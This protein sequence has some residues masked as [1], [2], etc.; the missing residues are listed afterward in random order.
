MVKK[1]IKTE[2]VEREYTIP[3]RDKCRSAVRYKKTPKAVKSVKE[4]LARHM[5]IYDRDLKKI[6]IDRYLNEYLW[7]RGIKN[8]P[9]KLKVKVTKKGEVVQVEL[10]EMPKKLKVKKAHEEKREAKSKAALELNKSMI[11]KAKENLKK[12][13]V[14]E[15]NKEEKEEKQEK[16]KE[17]KSAVAEQGAKQQKQQAKQS[18]HMTNAKSSTQLHREQKIMSSK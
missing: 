2:K 15:E 11:Q 16:E 4:F 9:H 3:L 17:K 1:E 13:K 14:K 6:K 10:A 18:K 7:F 5:K 12:P 8:P